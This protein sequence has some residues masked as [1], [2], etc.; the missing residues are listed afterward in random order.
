MAVY[1]FC[2]RF[3]QRARR[4]LLGLNERILGDRH[5]VAEH[6]TP[7]YDPWDQRLCAV[8]DADL[9][10]AIK[11]GRV[12]MV[13]ERIDSFVAEGIRLRDGRV[14]PADIVVTATGLK[15]LPFGGV[16]PSVDGRPVELSEQ[17]V[18]QGAML[19][20]VPN[21]AVCMGYTNASWTLRA[22][23]TH[24]LVCRVLN[25]LARHDLVA[26]VPA[27]REQLR[28]RPLLDLSSGY[29]QRSISQFPQQ[30]HRGPWRVRQ[31]YLLD[32]VTTM[33]RDLRR[34]LSFT[35]RA[36]GAGPRA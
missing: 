9:F 1:Q 32:S 18:W 20:G 8:P 4:V 29:I 30:G 22:D 2:R 25:H 13:T 5:L 11:R 34:S 28:P 19:T 21:F 12:S 26:A 6:F 14:L 31:N 15:L 23:L 10:R 33:R 24:R 17:F 27:P 7:T 16:V 35:A 36:P 3:P